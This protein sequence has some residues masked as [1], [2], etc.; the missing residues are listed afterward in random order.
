MERVNG[1]KLAPLS[2]SALR[3]PLEWKPSP[4]LGL[5]PRRPSRSSTPS[6]PSAPILGL[7]LRATDCAKEPLDRLPHLFSNHVADHGEPVGTTIG[8]K[9]DVTPELGRRGRPAAA[10]APPPRL[11]RPCDDPPDLAP[12]CILRP[13]PPARCEHP[14]RCLPGEHPGRATRTR[15]GPRS[16]LA[17]RQ[18]RDCSLLP[19]RA[20]QFQRRWGLINLNPARRATRHNYPGFTVCVVEV[21][22]GSVVVVAGGSEVVVGG[23]VVEVEEVVEVVGGSVVEVVVGGNVV[24]VSGG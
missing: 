13:L 23:S 7:L 24:V 15:C 18:G 3:A 17:A 1:E 14:E 6:P 2:R 21:V 20:G 4:L 9:V 16:G 12:L 5:R 8:G 10:L 11:A 22:G 19:S